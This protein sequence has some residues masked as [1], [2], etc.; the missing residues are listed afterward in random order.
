MCDKDD[1]INLYHT[2]NR[3][4]SREFRWYITLYAS[5]SLL[6]FKAL[7]AQSARLC[8]IPFLY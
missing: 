6:L 4:E 8:L 5:L 7:E 3:Y 1:Y 2:F